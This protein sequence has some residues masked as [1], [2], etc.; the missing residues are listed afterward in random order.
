MITALI[1]V[2]VV[3]VLIIKN[4]KMRNK[5]VRDV[6]QQAVVSISNE[7][8]T[9]ITLSLLFIYTKEQLQ[10]Q[11]TLVN[12][13]ANDMIK[14]LTDWDL[15]KVDEVGVKDLLEKMTDAT[16]K[17]LYQEIEK[18]KIDVRECI[19]LYSSVMPPK[20]LGKLLDINSDFR[21]DYSIFGESLE[22][23]IRVL[24]RNYKNKENTKAAFIT[25][26]E[27]DLEGYFENVKIFR[28]SVQDENW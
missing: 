20:I 2:S 8:V 25:S 26:F 16:W 24:L 3:N 13:E 15:N 23:L 22:I 28:K 5:E 12:K 17:S 21:N 11:M 9:K 10:L 4:D 1:T 18:L 7:L 27:R 19:S 6:A 14:T